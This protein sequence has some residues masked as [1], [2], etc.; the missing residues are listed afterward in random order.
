MA[1]KTKRNIPYSSKKHKRNH[2]TPT[3]S[4]QS[5]VPTSTKKTA[6]TPPRPRAPR[7]EIPSQKKRE[8]SKRIITGIFTAIIFIGLIMTPLVGAF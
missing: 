4:E 2:T 5:S 6:P 8:R 3:A 1:K 7:E